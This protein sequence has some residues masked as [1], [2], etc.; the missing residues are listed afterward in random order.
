[1]AQHSRDGADEGVASSEHHGRA[2]ERR[3]RKGVANNLFSF[4]AATNVRRGGS[5]VRANAGNMDEPL[6]TRFSGEPRDPCRGCYMD[7]MECLL[8]ALHIETHG[9]HDALD[10]GYGSGNGA[11]IIDVGM[12]RLNAKLNVGEKGCGAFWMPR[13]DPHRKIALK[14]TLD[15]A[16]AEK[17]SPTEYGHLSSC[18]RSIPR[19]MPL[20][21]FRRRPAKRDG[22]CWGRASFEQVRPA[23]RQVRVIGH[24]A[25]S[26]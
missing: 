2:D 3:S 18:H 16:V 7:G 26:K 5:G 4:P 22:D 14:Q 8:A 13:C 6:D 25:F 20:C 23:K 12:D 10:T 15:N 19:P 11:I 9:I 24:V 17:A 1:M 21:R